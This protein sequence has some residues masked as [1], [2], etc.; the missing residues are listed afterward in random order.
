LQRTYFF[1]NRD[2]AY[3]ANKFSILKLMRNHSDAV[4]GYFNQKNIS[5]S[6]EQQLKELTNYCNRLLAKS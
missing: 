4:I 3:E 2:Q 5:L 6:N 1:I